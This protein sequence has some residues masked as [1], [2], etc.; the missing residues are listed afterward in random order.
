MLQGMAAR[1]SSHLCYRFQAASELMAKRWTPLILQ[2]LQRRPRRYAELARALDMMSERIL[3]QRLKE[4]ERAG[5]LHRRVLAE[6]RPVGVEYLL[7]KKGQALARVVD[8]LQR[9]ADE[10]IPAEP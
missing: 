1:I 5:I 10:W 8:G 9:W 3:I 7:S 6:E 4:L 2:Q